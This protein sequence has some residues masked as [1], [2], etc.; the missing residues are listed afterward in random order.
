MQIIHPFCLRP[1]Q[2]SGSKP[3]S[4]TATFSLNGVQRILLEHTRNQF[5]KETRYQ[6]ESLAGTLSKEGEPIA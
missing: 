4:P 5:Q 3:R 2:P 1:I 6:E